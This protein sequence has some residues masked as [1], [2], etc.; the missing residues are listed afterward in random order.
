MVKRLFSLDEQPLQAIANSSYNWYIPRVVSGSIIQVESDDLPE[1]LSIK[2][3]MLEI[4][5]DVI[6]IPAV[7]AL[8]ETTVLNANVVVVE[9]NEWKAS[10]G[11]F[12]GDAIVDGIRLSTLLINNNLATPLS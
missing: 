3:K 9:F 7:T 8:L 10:Q 5:V 11:R 2:L 6:D 4:N 12:G 1:E